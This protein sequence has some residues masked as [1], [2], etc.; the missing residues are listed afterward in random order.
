MGVSL[1]IYKAAATAAGPALR[2]WLAVRAARG[3]EDTARLAERRGIPRPGAARPPGPLLWLHAASVGEA[4]SAL[5]LLERILDTR[6]DAHAL[7]TTGTVTAA[8]VMA[9]RLPPRAAHHY[10]PLDVPA[11]AGR[12]LD[13]WRPDAALWMESELWPATLSA[14]AARGVPAALVNARLSPRSAARWVRAPALAR[15]VLSPFRAV[16]AQTPADADRLRA[17][18]ARDAQAVGNLKYAAAP[19][20]A[21]P[22]DLAAL[23]RAIE[24]RPRWLYASTHA[25]EE[26]IAARAHAALAPR[27]PGLLTLIVPRHP[28]RRA[29]ISA[30]TPGARFRGPD[31][32]L[33]QPAD[34]LYVA[35][36]MGELGL[37]Y[38]A[39]PVAVI[40]RSLSAD[41]GGGHNPIEAAQLS[42]LPLHG[43][44]VGNLTAIYADMDAVG[45]A[46][47]VADEGALIAALDT[48][49]TNP[50]ETARAGMRAQAFVQSRADVLE[51]VTWHVLNALG[52]RTGA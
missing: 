22:G 40:G 30:E 37:F 32:T 47:E 15:A 38:R 12:F 45:A 43:P 25:G 35:D 4:T 49:L 48:A 3:K 19:L 24:G 9:A 17:L 7:V 33:P 36:T 20:P 26:A 52:W 5:T 39:A 42:C 23:M 29:A 14:L 2:A 16:L 10:A 44:R 50:S 21:D 1:A 46:R 34:G 8:R 41:G 13:F 51:R 11:W 6:P 28:A 31:K 27:H 18:G